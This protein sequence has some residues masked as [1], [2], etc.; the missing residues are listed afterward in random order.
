M[1]V[2]VNK[3]MATGN[4]GK[5]EFTELL[6]FR[7]IETTEYLNEKACSVRQKVKRIQ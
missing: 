5:E 2:L 3:L 6:R 1:D 7:N 4:L